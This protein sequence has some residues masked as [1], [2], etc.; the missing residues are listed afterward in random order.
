[1]CEEWGGGQGR[2]PGMPCVYL[3]ASDSSSCL[4]CAWWMGGV[5][6]ARRLVRRLLQAGELRLYLVDRLHREIDLEW[7]RGKDSKMTPR[8][9]ALL[10]GGPDIGP[11]AVVGCTLGTRSR[12]VGKKVMDSFGHVESE[13][14]GRH[15]LNQRLHEGRP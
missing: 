1:M 12:C 15:P 5:E 7:V 9:L 11:L 13:V 3:C 6:W 8:R 10:S 14:P 2:G 4:Q